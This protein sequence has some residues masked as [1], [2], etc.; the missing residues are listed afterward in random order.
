MKAILEFNLPEETIEHD[1]A[2]NGWK[3]QMILRQVDSKLR[4]RIKYDS[5]KDWDYDTCEEIR[6]LIATTCLDEGV[7]LY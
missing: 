3:W 7:E 1:L 6:H 4:D 2:I 5:N